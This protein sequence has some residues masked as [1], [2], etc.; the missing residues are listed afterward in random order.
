MLTFSK[1]QLPDG[2]ERPQR[3]L[4]EYRALRHYYVPG[5]H[6]PFVPKKAPET[7]SGNQP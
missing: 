3:T 7:S 4:E 1:K 5:I 6:N 2:Y